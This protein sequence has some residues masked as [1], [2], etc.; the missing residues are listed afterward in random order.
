M[1]GIAGVFSADKEGA[2]GILFYMLYALQHRGQQSCGIAVSD[3]GKIEYHKDAGLVNEVF[4]EESMRH[5]KGDMAIGHVRMAAKGEGYDYPYV[6]P[7]VAGYKK[8]SLAIVHDGTIANFQSIRKELEDQ[9]CLFQS[10]LDTEVI[11]N[12]IAR[13]HKDSMAD[14]V[15]KTVDQ[16]TGSYGFIVMTNGSLYAA[17]DYYGIKPLSIGILNG[18]YLVASETCAFDSIGAKFVR[19]ME[20]GE[21]VEITEEGLKIIREGDPKR[22]K[23]GIFEM[24][25]IA[26]PDSLIDGRSIYLARL[27]AGKI[28]AKEHPCD[29]DLVIGAPDSGIS[30]AIGYAEASKLPYSEG[31][32]K[33]RYVGRTF[34]Q[35]SQDLRDIG[36]KIKLNPL[37]E[38]IENKRLVL[39]D[40][41]IVRGTTM[42]RTVKMLRD[43]GA[44]EVHIRVGSPPV[45]YSS[46]LVTDTPTQEE[47]MAANHSKE[48]MAKILDCDSLEF[49][50]LEGLFEALGGEDFTQACFTGIFPKGANDTEI[51]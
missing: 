13:N 2:A 44:K 51:K 7:I 32:I 5:L 22:R 25:Y 9:G 43:A 34:I 23:L 45:L 40:D 6:Q 46:K 16:L 21:V 47:L 37:K 31:I 11:A 28:L 38:Y 26:R 49:I 41:S 42:K 36:V 18:R 1:S 3:G 17:R 14:A 30:F 24:V 29:A 33:N 39:V 20:P 12:L 27:N 50:S 10:E 15:N 35:P 19:D 4:D 8:G 48:E